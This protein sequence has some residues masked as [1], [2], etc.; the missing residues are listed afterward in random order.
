L[1]DNKDVQH[2]KQSGTR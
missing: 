1:T 2:T